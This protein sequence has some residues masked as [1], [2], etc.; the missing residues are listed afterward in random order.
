MSRKPTVL[1]LTLLACMV[2][3]L[4][5]A[6]PARSDDDNT[7]AGVLSGNPGCRVRF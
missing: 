6:S 7:V 1:K 5:L 4:T 2:L 3:A